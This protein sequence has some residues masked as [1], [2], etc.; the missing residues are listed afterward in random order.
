MSRREPPCCTYVR[1]WTTTGFRAL[2][3][4]SCQRLGASVQLFL[5]EGDL[6]HK[7]GLQRAIKRRRGFPLLQ[8]RYGIQRRAV[9]CHHEMKMRTGGKACLSD[10]PNPLPLLDRVSRANTRSES[11]DSG[12]R[13]LPDQP[14]GSLRTSRRRRNAE[15]ALRST[16][17]DRLL[18]SPC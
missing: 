15:I 9:L 5:N 1:R 13:R 4:S 7:F 6:F 10:Q 3:T 11:N 8:S 17:S 16:G 18:G 2:L 14:P 12:G